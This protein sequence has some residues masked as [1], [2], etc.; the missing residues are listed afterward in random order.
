M[1]KVDT[2]LAKPVPGNQATAGVVVR[3]E[4]AEDLVET[5]SFGL[6]NQSRRQRAAEAAPA[7]ERTHIDAA[8][9]HSRIAGA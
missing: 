8:L 4:L 7:L 2:N 3:E 9:P 1:P 6:S 5:G